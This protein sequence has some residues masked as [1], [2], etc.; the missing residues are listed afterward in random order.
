[1]SKKKKHSRAAL[2]RVQEET[3]ALPLEDG[4]RLYGRIDYAAKPTGKAVIFAHGLTGNMYEHQ[5]MLARTFFTEHGYDVIRF[6]FYGEEAD[7][8]R[9]TDSSV[10]QHA[11]DLDRLLQHFSTQY[12]SLCVAGHSF[13]GLALLMSNSPHIAAASMWDG[14]FIPFAEDERFS[15]CWS[16]NE[17]LGEYAVNWAPVTKVVGKK[18]YDETQ[19]FTTE[20]MKQWAKAF[21]RPV[22]VVAAGAYEENL[23]YQKKLFK[24]LSSEKKEYTKISGASHGFNEGNTVFELIEGTYKFFEKTF[25]SEFNKV[26]KKPTKSAPAQVIPLRKI[27][28][29]HCR[30]V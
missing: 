4:H 23:P 17:S 26:S 6:N 20:R 9:I 21:T 22:Q 12:D 15:K 11:K 13:G 3:F 10:A 29:S 14:T 19:T 16:Y 5:Y 8:R 2:A 24:T 1:M 28:V 30:P 7:S 27:P 18:F 25:S